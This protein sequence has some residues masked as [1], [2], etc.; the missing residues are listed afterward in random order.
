MKKFSDEILN[1]TKDVKENN[2]M[3]PLSCLVFS[4]RTELDKINRM[5]S[6]NNVENALESLYEK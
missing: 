6:I 1:N 2:K 4:A 5:K 3:D